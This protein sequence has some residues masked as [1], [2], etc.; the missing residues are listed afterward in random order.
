MRTVLSLTVVFGI[1]AG[2]SAQ[3]P[4]K[5]APPEQPAAPAY[6][7]PKLPLPPN[8]GSMNVVSSQAVSDKGKV[9]LFV[10]KNEPV[11][12][13]EAFTYI[14]QVP[15]TVVEDDGNG[16]KITKTVVKP[17]TKTGTR[18]V[19]KYVSVM[20]QYPVTG[21][22]KL[23]LTDAAGK[24]LSDD[25]VLKALEKP[26]FIFEFTDKPNADFLKTLQPE[27]VVLAWK[28]LPVDPTTAPSPPPKR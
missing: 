5:P 11:T 21:N 20:K 17:E 3:E 13:T 19:T 24:K 22:E 28:P 1:V 18:A 14:V 25:E 26:A 2:S 9:S 15:N 16:G 8:P 23:T 27:T 6:A 4:P 10:M 7:V 12:T